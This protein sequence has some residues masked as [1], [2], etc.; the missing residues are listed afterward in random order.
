MKYLPNFLLIALTLFLISCRSTDENSIV[1][2]NTPADTFF[3]INVGNK[4]VYKTYENGDFTNPQSPTT[5][6]GRIDS[7]SIVGTVNISGLTFSKQRTKISWP[8]SNLN[9]QESFKY[10]RINSKGHLVYIFNPNDPN[11]TET[12]GHV[13]HPGTD[14]NFTYTYDFIDMD[15]ILGNLFYKLSTDKNI[16]IEGNSYLVKPYLGDFTPAST[17]PNL[18]KKTQ[19]ISYKKGVGLVREICHSVYGKSYFETRLVSYTIK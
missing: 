6:T 17:Q 18:L 19:D 10:L 1:D 11:I 4:W 9:N 3:N 16:E 14:I 2:Q 12:S 7:V 15:Q 5:F 13:L 8:L